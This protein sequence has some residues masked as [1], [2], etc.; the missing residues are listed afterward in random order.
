MGTLIL[1][2]N[3]PVIQQAIIEASQYGSSFGLPT[4]IEVEM[5]KLVVE[6][7]KELIWFVWSIQELKQR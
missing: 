2:H 3:H 7:M 5:A 4:K 1:G 6:V